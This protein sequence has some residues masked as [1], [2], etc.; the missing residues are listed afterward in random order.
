MICVLTGHK[1]SQ[2]DSLCWVDAVGICSVDAGAA[3][4]ESLVRAKGINV[5]RLTLGCTHKAVVTWRLALYRER[6]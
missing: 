5:L 3:Q 1:E 2:A 4:P 6:L